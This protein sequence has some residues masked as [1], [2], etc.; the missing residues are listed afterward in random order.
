MQQ[1][2][3]PTPIVPLGRHQVLRTPSCTYC[4]KPTR[5]TKYKDWPDDR[6]TRDHVFPR[7]KGGRKTVPC[8]WACNKKKGNRMPTEQELVKSGLFVI[9][10][11]R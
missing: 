1:I 6:Y 2:E 4:G 5:R 3:L 9:L 11:A 8:C 10:E 7:S